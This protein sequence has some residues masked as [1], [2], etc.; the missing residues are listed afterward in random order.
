MRAL[1]RYVSMKGYEL[2]GRT[3]EP[4]ECLAVCEYMIEQSLSLHYALDMRLL[5]NSFH[6]Y[7]QWQYGDAAC[8]WSDLVA[9]RLRKR[10]VILKAEVSRLSRAERKQQEQR[11]V[12]E[13][14]DATAS[15]TERL[16]IWV[17][18][19]NKSPAAFYR[20]LKEVNG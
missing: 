3:M 12:R 17:E 4:A 7:L 13:I 8:H 1:M 19:T 10:P 2:D 16:A 6:D 15:P 11:I 9:T 5:V 18:R 14:I 20:R